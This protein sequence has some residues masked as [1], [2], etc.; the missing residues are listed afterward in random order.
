MGGPLWFVGA[1]PLGIFKAAHT[2]L[3]RL[4]E[5]QKWHQLAGSMGERC[6]VIIQGQTG[7]RIW[8]DSRKFTEPLGMADMPLF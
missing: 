3:A 7:S 5:S 8:A 6:V 2:V 1:E 4:M